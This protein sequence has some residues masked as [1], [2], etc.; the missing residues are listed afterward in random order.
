[1]VPTSDGCN[2]ITPSHEPTPAVRPDCDISE[3][4]RASLTT[5]QV[6]EGVAEDVEGEREEGDEEEARGRQSDRE[7]MGEEEEEDDGQLNW[8]YCTPEISWTSGDTDEGRNGDVNEE[9]QGLEEYGR[10]VYGERLQGD[11]GE[12]E[13]GEGDLE[14]VWGGEG[15]L[16]EEEGREGDVEEVGGD[17]SEVERWE[18]DSEEVEGGEGDV[19]EVGGD[20]SEV[21]RWEGDS[22]EVEGG[23]GDVEEVAR[24][25]I[26]LEG[27]VEPEEGSVVI[28]QDVDS[29]NLSI[30]S[31]SE[32]T[33]ASDEFSPTI[34]QPNFDDISSSSVTPSAAE[35]MT[36]STSRDT[37]NASSHHMQQSETE[38]SHTPIS[39][40][41]S[42]YS[43]NTQPNLDSAI[44][45]ITP[46]VA[47]FT[48][49]PD[50]CTSETSDPHVQNI[51]QEV[52]LHTPISLDSSTC[53]NITRLN[54]LSP[55][56]PS[57]TD[58][59]TPPASHNTCT[60]TSESSGQHVQNTAQQ[61]SS[62]TLISLD[63]PGMSSSVYYTASTHDVIRP[64]P[65]RATSSY[66][67][68]SVSPLC[69][70][71]PSPHSGA[72][73]M[74]SDVIVLDSSDDEEADSKLEDC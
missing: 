3:T 63:T 8:S 41:S 59:T 15:H 31:V 13:R 71:P 68:A 26:D 28:D 49:P 37:L 48:T 62:H 69:L 74:M 23:E 44:S 20:E 21:E 73:E 66:V 57:A 35:S 32:S 19:E 56:T 60:C 45:S 65:Q 40:N 24:E 34:A 18:G 50:T 36:P 11:L 6:N 22:E 72:R 12:V 9:I 7:R 58:Y 47:A 29:S 2:S 33:A 51:T 4:I 16:E 1:M 30:T 70:L 14:E 61:V 17:E 53:S 39:L 42:S 55:T 67:P 10:G 27:A 38:A 54:F 64:G 52:S 5:G 46:S 43:N 25:E